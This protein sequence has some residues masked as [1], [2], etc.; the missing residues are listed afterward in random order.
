MKMKMKMMEMIAIETE[1][2]RHNEIYISKSY[3]AIHILI[4]K[5][6]EIQTV[7]NKLTICKRE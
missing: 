1:F 7:S 4:R 2:G 3:N 6:K 5:S